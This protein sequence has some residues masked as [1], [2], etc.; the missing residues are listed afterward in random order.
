MATTFER[1]TEKQV[2]W[3]ERI[4]AE[5]LAEIDAF[6]AGLE[7]DAAEDGFLDDHDARKIR[8]AKVARYLVATEADAASLIDQRRQQPDTLYLD[9]LRSDRDFEALAKLAGV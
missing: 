4:R 6:V 5:K 1:G 7:A 9:L 3:A 2:A 8:H